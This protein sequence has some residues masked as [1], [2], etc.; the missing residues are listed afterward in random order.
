[1]HRD[2]EHDCT[3][4]VATADCTVCFTGIRLSG[5]CESGVKVS[6]RKEKG[7]RII[8][9]GT[10]WYELSGLRHMLSMRGY[11]VRNVLP[12]GCNVSDGGDL[13]IVALSA[14]SVAGWGRHLSRVC[15]LRALFSGKMLVLVPERLKSLNVLR[16]VSPVCSGRESLQQLSVYIDAV[17]SRKP[18]QT[19]RFRLTEAQRRVLER[20][21]EGDGSRDGPL[22]QA[23]SK[24]WLYRQCAQLA[25]NTG[26]R[27][28]RM[29]MLTR[30]DK[31]IV[32]TEQIQNIN[33]L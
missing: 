13:L 22:N 18:E 9:T 1:M 32:R 19:G 5:D 2:V 7:Q 28:F 30:L 23:Q 17:L 31:E 4:S 11:D 33:G 6:V 14:E 15:E 12:W 29:L 10:C 20:F 16:N 24:P 3:D 8:L 27:H 26:V 25:E 21:S